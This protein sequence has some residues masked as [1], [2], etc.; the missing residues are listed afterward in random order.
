M[1]DNKKVEKEVNKEKI[2][3]ILSR[4]LNIEEDASIVEE[5]KKL[6]IEIS[7]KIAKSMMDHVNKAFAA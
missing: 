3:R 1:F 5:E 4:V 6:P 7:E 2:K